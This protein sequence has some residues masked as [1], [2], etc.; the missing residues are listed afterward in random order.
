MLSMRR[1][2]KSCTTSKLYQTA[3]IAFTGV[4]VV[5]EVCVLKVFR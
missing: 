5:L 1:A 2:A 4:G 3:D